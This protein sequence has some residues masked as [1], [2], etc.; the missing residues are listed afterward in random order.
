[1]TCIVVVDDQGTS[2]RVI[3]KLASTIEDN[4][5]VVEFEDPFD[6]LSFFED[7][8]PDLVITDYSMPI[9]NG[10]E[11][12][13]RVRGMPK[14]HD[15]PVVVVTTY[16]NP[17]FRR[18]ALEAGS[19][20]YLSLPLNFDE[21]RLKSRNLL[22]LRNARRL[23]NAQFDSPTVEEVYACELRQSRARAE[24]LDGLVQTLSRRLV[25]K[26]KQ[27][28]LAEGDLTAFLD[29]SP[30]AAI[31][32]DEDLR[33]R[34]FTAAAASLFDLGT[35]D[36]GQD[37]RLTN[38]CLSHCNLADD[39]NAAKEQRKTIQ[40][41]VE[42][43]KTGRVYQIRMIPTKYNDDALWGAIISFDRMQIGAGGKA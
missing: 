32:V 26:I 20:E 12:I 34:R 9:I 22:A 35:K 14:C 29:V 39:L 36:I 23:A 21:F 25:E 3:S 27:L 1:M 33:I 2:R 42:L 13:R 4:A 19:T 7:N 6:A 16:T 5:A 24:L 10:A 31:F 38:I 28:D 41:F 15:V 17:E 18:L 30:Y 8:T 40:K 11:F 37:L 43:P